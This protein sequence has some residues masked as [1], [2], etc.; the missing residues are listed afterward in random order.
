MSVNSR[1]FLPVVIVLICTSQISGQTIT[2]FS[3]TFGSAFDFNFIDVFGT[4]F[5]PGT[6][7]LRFG[8]TVDP[9]AGATS[10]T[11]IQ[12]RVPTNAPLGPCLIS[13]SLNGGPPAFSTQSF[14]VIGRGPFVTNFTPFA[15]SANTNVTVG[16]AH[17][18]GVTNVSFN[19]KPGTGLIVTLEY[20]LTVNAPNGVTTGPITVIGTN[21]SYT[22][23][24]NF[25][26][27]PVITGL[28]PPI[29][30]SGTNVL[31]MGNNFLGTTTIFFGATSTTNFSVLSN[32]AVRVT[33]P[34]GAQTGKLTLVAPAGPFQTTSNFV[35]QPTI[36]G[37]SPVFGPAGTSVTITGANF[38]VGTPSVRFGGVPAATP[39]GVTFSQLTA[40]VPSGATSGPVTL[41]T[42]D[43]NFTT[44]NLFYLPANITTF[45]PTNSA[46]GTIV[47]ITGVNFTNASAVTFNGTAAS[48]VAT[49]NTTIGVS[50]PAGFSTGPISVTT[51]AGT[52]N[53]SSLFYAAP[54][55]TGFSPTH[56]L[57]GTNV[58]ISGSNFL[59]ASLVRFNGTTANSTPPT[60]NTT[61]VATV[62]NGAQTGPITIVAPAGTNTSATNFVVDNTSDLAVGV[63]G[64]PNPVFLGSNL[65]YTIAVT[66]GGPF[67]AGNVR[68]TN[69][70]PSSVALK[71]AVTTR[72]TLSTNSNPITGVLGNITNGTGV[73][74]T[75]TVVPNTPGTIVNIAKVM[76]DNPDP[77]LANNMFSVT[78]T[79]SPLPL[80]TIRRA[81][82]GRLNISWPVALTNFGLQFKTVLS[83]GT[84][85]S[86]DTT[87]P[88]ISGDQR[89]VTETN[90][91]NAKFYRLKK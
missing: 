39:T 72:G 40:I 19:G 73:V 85:W 41:T 16:G 83:T 86:D 4:G 31:L 91:G 30:R 74:I 81:T 67:V 14:M 44:A 90:A 87:T 60:N 88:V 58:V 32:N 46:P 34:N 42:T 69:T 65:T 47:R 20:S 22:T 29:G 25:F 2:S 24:S 66:T 62:P 45:T 36:F 55:I 35:I 38:N 84:S 11:H 80:L 26:V 82:P 50:V 63:I 89:I 70:L 6:V 56:G 15:G 8:N 7:V 68:L 33:V 53:S 12:A 23:T 5:A 61:L 75:L 27:P 59:G 10:T 51:P 28:S 49:N 48:F 9:T 43:G 17:F 54:V 1:A 37:F 21:G 76:S 71:S 52:T 64:A 77:A 13:V 3:P 78:N 79:V 57:P 18:A